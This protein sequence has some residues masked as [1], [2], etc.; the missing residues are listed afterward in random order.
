MSIT[1]VFWLYGRSGAGKTTLARQLHRALSDRK[2]PVFYL[3]GDDL[4]SGLCADLS[5]T[6][7]ARLENHRRLAEVAKLAANQGFNVVVSSMAPQHG[8]R[9]IVRQILGEK[10]TWIHIHAP[11][12]VCIQ[13][14][15]KGLYRRAQAGKLDQLINYPFDAPRPDEKEHH[16]D[17]VEHDVAGA[18]QKILTV[19][20]TILPV[21]RQP[22][23]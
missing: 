19:V 14:D 21:D 17:T 18:A 6:P 11:L 20:Q 22:S 12:E 8:H 16:I 10:L 13:R 3:D 2:I 9:D 15:P 7:E 1:K 23:A 4:R 5:F